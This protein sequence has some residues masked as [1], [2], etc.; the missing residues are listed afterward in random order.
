M[1]KP[2]CVT[3]TIVISSYPVKQ[4]LLE[5]P[6]NYP[7]NR[8]IRAIRRGKSLLRDANRKNRARHEPY[9]VKVGTELRLSVNK[10]SP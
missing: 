6:P 2:Y 4:H 10:R 9:F 7:K 5:L 3:W 8:A 1:H